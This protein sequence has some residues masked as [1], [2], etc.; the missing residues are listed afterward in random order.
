M[1]YFEKG[2]LDFFAALQNNN[3]KE[4]F[5][6]NRTSYEK[7]VKEPFKLFV[8]EMI[9][10]ISA[11]D[12]N[13]RVEPKECIYRINRDIRFSKD[14]TPYKTNVSANIGVGGRKNMVHPGVYI[15]LSAHDLRIY[16]GVY[17]PE[18]DQLHRIRTSIDTNLSEFQSL[19]SDKKF[20]K[21]FGEIRGEANK[22]IPKEFREAFEKEPLIANKQFYFFK[23]YDAQSILE[24]DLVD[25]F[26]A[27]YKTAKPLMHFFSDSLID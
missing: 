13:I 3:S 20:V 17:M 23:K 26:M 1:T 9:A 14:K 25:K 8:S 19:I 27:D 15:E 11:L 21:N 22:I 7:C 18:K 10:R 2:F 4:W 16:S 5:D 24:S 12:S 6:A